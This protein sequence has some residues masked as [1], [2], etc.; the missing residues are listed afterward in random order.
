[1]SHL[2]AAKLLGLDR[3][4]TGEPVEFTTLRE[5]RSR[6]CPYTVHT[7]ISMPRLDYVEVDG[8]RCTSG[9]RT[10]LDLA[11]ARVPVARLEAA[12]DSSV[13]LGWSAPLV[14]VSR[15]AEFRGRGRYGSPLLDRLLI[16]SGGHTMLERRF[17]ELMRK[18]GLPR[19]RTQVVHKRDRTTVARVDFLFEAYDVVIETD[20]QRGHASPAERAKDAQR[21]GELQDLGKRVYEYTWEDVTARPAY[22]ERTLIERLHTAGWRR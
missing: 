14:I 1:V 18:A 20:G 4:K 10:V 11:H 8:L 3:T 12:I 7:T 17:L 15:L 6:S 22:V 2:A 16:D 5:F 19:P 9:T 13:R 21:R